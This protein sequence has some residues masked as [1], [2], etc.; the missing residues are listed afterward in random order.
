MMS[1]NDCR[2]NAARCVELGNEATSV[3]E[4][5]LLFDMARRWTEIAERLEQS[6]VLQA[7]LRDATVQAN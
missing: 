7:P 2:D 6:A 1:P 3:E 5:N 4:Q